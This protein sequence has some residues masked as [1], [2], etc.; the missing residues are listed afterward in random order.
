MY[1]IRLMLNGT[2]AYYRCVYG[3]WECLHKLS[4]VLAEGNSYTTQ[5]AN[6]ESVH[7]CTFSKAVHQKQV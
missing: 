5:L 6:G 1:E 3:V 4:P 2:A 7:V